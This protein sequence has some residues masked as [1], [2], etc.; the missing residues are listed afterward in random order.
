MSAFSSD[1]DSSSMAG[2]D[3]DSEDSDSDAVGIATSRHD[4]PSTNEY[5]VEVDIH[6]R[7]WLVARE[8]DEK[9]RKEKLQR[10]KGWRE[11]TWR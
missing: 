8:Q 3:T 6:S 5:G 11:E 9:L 1:S 2:S 7:N 10:L 4:D